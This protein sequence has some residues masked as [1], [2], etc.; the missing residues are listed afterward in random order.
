MGKPL[1]Y[2]CD[3]CEKPFKNDAGE[4]PHGTL[5]WRRPNPLLKTSGFYIQWK[6]CESCWENIKPLLTKKLGRPEKANN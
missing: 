2:E 4:V 1:N 6:L 3:F 5:Q